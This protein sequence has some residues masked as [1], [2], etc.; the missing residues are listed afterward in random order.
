MINLRYEENIQL[1]KLVIES[2][3]DEQRGD[4]PIHDSRFGHAR[5]L[6]C[7]LASGLVC[8]LAQGLDKET[9]RIEKEKNIG[10]MLG[11]ACA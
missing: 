7:N 4:S 2:T 11:H 10:T 1:T 6:V 8:S 5:E 3:K 9:E